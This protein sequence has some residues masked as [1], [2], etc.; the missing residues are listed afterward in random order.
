MKEEDHFANFEALV[1]PSERDI[2][3]I[4][5]DKV[6]QFNWIKKRD[7]ITNRRADFWKEIEKKRNETSVES[8]DLWTECQEY[9]KDLTYTGGFSLVL[10]KIKAVITKH[11]ETEAA[12]MKNAGFNHMVNSFYEDGLNQAMRQMIEAAA[13]AQLD[14]DILAKQ[15]ELEAQIKDREG[16][17]D[18]DE[19][20]YQAKLM[21]ARA[22]Q[23]VTKEK[24]VAIQED[25]EVL[26]W[27]S[28]KSK[29]FSSIVRLK[30]ELKHSPNQT[31]VRKNTEGGDFEKLKAF[32]ELSKEGCI[33]KAREK[34][35]VFYIPVKIP[36][37]SWTKAYL[38]PA[39]A[40]SASAESESVPTNP[41]IVQQRENSTLPKEN[42][43]ET[44]K[45]N[46]EVYEHPD[47]VTKNATP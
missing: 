29:V 25:S 22:A 6:T 19:P 33:K 3:E 2:Q 18:H 30:S 40:E 39:S 24:I 17:K 41:I 38:S 37:L 16:F 23:Q 36:E 15:A 12:L 28:Y 26:N 35:Q 10:N 5:K 11:Q 4:L 13:K 32:K 8:Q 14:E 44:D 20:I 21:E 43:D 45:N 31:A 47:E 27:F 9:Q 42:N 46:E 1:R 34:N 7:Y